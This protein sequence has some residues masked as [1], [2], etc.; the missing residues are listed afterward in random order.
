MAAEV[1]NF[2]EYLGVE[3]EHYNE[4]EA[5]LTM[6]LD[7]HHEQHLSFVHGGVIASLADNTGWFVA[8]AHL[9]E[10][11]TVVTQELSISY[12]RPAKGKKLKSVGN[13][14]KQGRRSLFVK[15]EV[16]CDD[17]LVAYCTSNL[18]V[19]ETP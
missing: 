9:E 13:L 17:V 1:F 5:V 8:A 18:A 11:T 6:D 4:D 7:V 12:L 10:G 2:L 19:V 16:F 3:I 14:I 15:A